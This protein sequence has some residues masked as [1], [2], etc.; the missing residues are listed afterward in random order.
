MASLATM[1]T[2]ASMRTASG[3]DGFVATHPRL[4]ESAHLSLQ[5]LRTECVTCLSIINRCDRHVS[6]G[7]SY[8]CN[9]P[10]AKYKH[11]I[12]DVW[13]FAMLLLVVLLMLLTGD[14]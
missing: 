4:R 10:F 8:V 3:T 7:G 14:V 5:S 1:S 6:R 13:L 2:M 12:V 11:A 9:Q